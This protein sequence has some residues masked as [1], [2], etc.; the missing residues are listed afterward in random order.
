[1]AAH[2]RAVAPTH[3]GTIEPHRRAPNAAYQ[4]VSYPGSRLKLEG[5]REGDAR[6][7]GPRAVPGKIRRIA[8]GKA[9]E[10]GL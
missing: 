2:D 7:D 4:S 6:H 10:S 5:V 8:L 3:S 1:M 9:R